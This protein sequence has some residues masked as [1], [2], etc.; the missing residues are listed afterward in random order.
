MA[1]DVTITA[2]QDGI[3]LATRPLS[4]TM[5]VRAA[6]LL[7]R[8][9]SLVIDTLLCPEDMAPLLAI[10]ARHGRPVVVVNTHS[11][12]DHCWGNAAFPGA[13]IVGHRLCRERILQPD[14]SFVEQVKAEDPARY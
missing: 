4:E 10:V 11:D 9:R 3:Y 8:R 13:P 6:L 2:L 5:V 12:W 1:G 14:L 7:G